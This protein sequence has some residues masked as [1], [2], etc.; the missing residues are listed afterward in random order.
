[1]DVGQPLGEAPAKCECER[2]TPKRPK[3]L[4]VSSILLWLGLLVC[5]IYIC[6]DAWQA[7]QDPNG[8]PGGHQ[9]LIFKAD[10]GMLATS[11]RNKYQ[12]M[13]VENNLVLIPCDGPYLVY[14]KVHSSKL[15]TITIRYR[16]G[17]KLSALN[18]SNDVDY[19]TVASLMFKDKLSLEVTDTRN[20]TEHI[21]GELGL[22]LLA[23]KKYC[24]NN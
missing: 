22:I 6:W 3:L 17:E 16:N 14:L 1:M 19:V 24:S 18:L 12:S 9:N 4:L 23:P 10:I 15:L 8:H 13:K 5:L 11:Y 21:T 7:S 2:R 20:C